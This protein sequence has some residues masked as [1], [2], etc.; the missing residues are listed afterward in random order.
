MQRNTNIKS[1]AKPASEISLG[2]FVHGELRTAIRS[3][4]YQPGQ[5]IREA[6]VAGW[7][8]VS[9]TPVREAFKRLQADGL[10]LL[11]RWRGAEV[12]ELNQEQVVE[13]YAMRR[14]LEGTAA[15]LAAEYASEKEIDFLFD[16]LNRDKAASGDPDRL[17]DL[18]RL[19]HEALYGAAHNRYLLKALSSLGDS[20]ALLRSTTYEVPGRAAAAHDDHISIATAIKNRN[21]IAA[22][23]A[24][25]RHIATAVK[26][27]LELLFG[28][29]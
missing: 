3:R 22:E 6:E 17:A 11:T 7:L 8:G 13:L 9:R 18:N 1:D 2:E 12:S 20:L 10:I 15:S 21:P 16:L 24:A 29:E 27:R 28:A 14:V 23:K 4:R 26:A 25:Q 5:R 19:F